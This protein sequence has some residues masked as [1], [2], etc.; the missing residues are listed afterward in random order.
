M[1]QTSSESSILRI[2][3]ETA[4][5]FASKVMVR[6][7]PSG[8]FHGVAGSLSLDPTIGLYAGLLLHARN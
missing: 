2:G 6:H 4:I 8:V 1:I 5:T 3:W 7:S